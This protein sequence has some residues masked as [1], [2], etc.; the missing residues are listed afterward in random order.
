MSEFD[1]ST[2]CINF[3][4][5]SICICIMIHNSPAEDSSLIFVVK[6]Q[7]GNLQ[8]EIEGKGRNK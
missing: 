4:T 1:M 3:D 7:S 8:N 5:Y 2:I 6:T